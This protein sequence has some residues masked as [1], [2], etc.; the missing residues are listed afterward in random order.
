[1]VRLSVDDRRDRDRQRDS[2]NRESMH[3]HWFLGQIRVL[4]LCWSDQ[5]LACVSVDDSDKKTER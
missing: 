3:V 4:N 2:G 1:M 5:D